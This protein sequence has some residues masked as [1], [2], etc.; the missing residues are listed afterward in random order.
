MDSLTVDNTAQG[1]VLP[2][3]QAR[4]NTTHT[5]AP[6]NCVRGC[7]NRLSVQSKGS[8][9]SWLDRQKETWWYGVARDG[10]RGYVASADRTNKIS[11]FSRASTCKLARQEIRMGQRKLCSCRIDLLSSRLQLAESGLCPLW[12]VE[13]VE[14]TAELRGEKEKEKKKR[15]KREREREEEREEKR[16]ERRGKKEARRR[17]EEERRRREEGRGKKGQEKGEKGQ[18]K[19]K[20][21][22]KKE[23]K[24]R[25]GDDRIL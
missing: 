11:D 22:E 21:S 16:E 24:R 14:S 25:R 23:E 15:K 18:E 17:G 7:A 12:Q 13:K 1:S 20:G 8:E 2:H 5:P 4:F 9:K 6:K 19:G 10:S 3:D